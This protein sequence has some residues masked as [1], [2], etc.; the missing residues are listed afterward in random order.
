L[1]FYLDSNSHAAVMGALAGSLSGEVVA[2]F[3]GTLAMLIGVGM[4]A[5]T[6]YNF[7]DG[8]PPGVDKLAVDYHIEVPAGDGARVAGEFMGVEPYSLISELSSR[9]RG[10][11]GLGSVSVVDMDA[12]AMPDVTSG[13][14]YSSGG[15]SFSGYSYGGSGEEQDTGCKQ[16]DVGKVVLPDGSSG[17][18]ML[19]SNMSTGEVQTLA[20]PE[21]YYGAVK[22]LCEMN[23]IAAEG[24]DCKR[25]SAMCD[26]MMDS[27]FGSSEMSKEFYGTPAPPCEDEKPQGWCNKVLQKE[28]CDK[29]HGQKCKLSCGL[30]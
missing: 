25:S 18:V 3:E 2:A 19:L 29:A 22:V 8:D 24:G 9:L 13:G 16:L 10:V 23:E 21:G 12:I 27:C 7:R 1:S 20:C 14:G 26:E 5:V 11:Q 17:S 28:L 6:V 30:C 15:Y 4:H